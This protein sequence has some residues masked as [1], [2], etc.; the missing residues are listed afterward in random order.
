MDRYSLSGIPQ[1]KTPPTIDGEVGKRE[2]Y[3]AA[4]LPRMISID[5]RGIAQER[6]RVFVAYDPREGH[7]VVAG[8]IFKQY[9][10]SHSDDL[11]QPLYLYKLIFHR[12]LI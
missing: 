4:L 6:S 1:I 5:E 8:V 12:Y 7:S 2:R 10:K 11:F 9:F 3:G